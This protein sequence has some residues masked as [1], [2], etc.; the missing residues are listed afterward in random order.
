MESLESERYSTIGES[1][2]DVPMTDS[3]IFPHHQ[4]NSDSGE[5]TCIEE[6]QN[7]GIGAADIQKL[8]LAGICTVKV[9][10]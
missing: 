9:A 3:M 8:K 7:Y 10:C 5:I 2:S 4:A 6:L 1:E